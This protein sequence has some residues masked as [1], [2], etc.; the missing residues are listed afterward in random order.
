MSDNPIALKTGRRPLDLSEE[1]S[2]RI[3]DVIGDY[4][5]MS[6]PLS[7][8]VGVLE[9]VKLDLIRDHEFGN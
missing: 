9:M 8:V 6:V 1:M 5:S 2:E 7:M 4:T 3:R